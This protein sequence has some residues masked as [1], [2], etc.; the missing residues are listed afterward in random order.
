MV[1]R[2]W[3]Q[4]RRVRRPGAT[5][6]D[7]AI[8]SRF[9]MHAVAVHVGTGCAATLADV[10]GAARCQSRTGVRDP[11]GGRL[12]RR[13]ARAWRQL[14][15]RCRRHSVDRIRSSLADAQRSEEHTSELQSLMRISY[16]VFC[17]KKKNSTN[18]KKYTY[19]TI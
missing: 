11:A 12:A 14:L 18:T 2:R 3:F 17:L 10:L 19:N 8:D 6:S 16:A 13:A 5:R 1:G 9:C 15:S 4:P 7:P